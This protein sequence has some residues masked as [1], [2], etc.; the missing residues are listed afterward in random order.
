MVELGADKESKDTVR[1]CRAIDRGRGREL[2]RG[3]ASGMFGCTAARMRDG[4]RRRRECCMY[5][6]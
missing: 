5:D 2:L 6:S 3:T 4:G 1:H